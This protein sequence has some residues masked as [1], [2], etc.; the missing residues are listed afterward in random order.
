VTRL[1]GCDQHG[2]KPDIAIGIVRMLREPGCGGSRN[3]AL[4]AFGDA[5]RRVVEPRTRLN[6][7]KHQHVSAPLDDIDVANRAAQAPRNDT[8]PLGN[9]ISGRAAFRRQSKP[10]RNLTLRPRRPRFQT[11]AVITASHRRPHC[12]SASA[13]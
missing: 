11:L 5:F 2:I 1:A 10:K 3:S 8:I 12:L 9:E 13:R 4:L 6:L 7:D